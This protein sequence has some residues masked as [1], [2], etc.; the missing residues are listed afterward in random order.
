MGLPE[1]RLLMRRSGDRRPAR[2]VKVQELRRLKADGPVGVFVDD[3][4]AVQHAARRAGF[5]VFAADW[6]PTR[7]AESLYAAQESDGET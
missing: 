2:S 5:A 3:D 6:M 4:T 7:G 1:G